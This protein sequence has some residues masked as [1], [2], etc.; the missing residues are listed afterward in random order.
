MAKFV[1]LE[2]SA[3][4][5]LAEQAE[6]DAL[7]RLIGLRRKI[8]EDNK[9]TADRKARLWWWSSSLLTVGLLSSVLCIVHTS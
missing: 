4:R 9:R 2:G 3:L 8:Y 5:C 6:E 7:R 1:D